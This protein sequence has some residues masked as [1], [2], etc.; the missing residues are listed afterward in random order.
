MT[1]K[2]NEIRPEGGYEPAGG[3]YENDR[4]FWGL[5]KMLA[6]QTFSRRNVFRGVN[7]S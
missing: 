2:L 1:T 5:R 4:E 3:L 6:E 7:S